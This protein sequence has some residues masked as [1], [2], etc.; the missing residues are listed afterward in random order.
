MSE[1]QLAFKL[2]DETF[3]STDAPYVYIPIWQR[4]VSDDNETVKFEPRPAEAPNER[5]G[6]YWECLRTYELTREDLNRCL[7]DTDIRNLKRVLIER[8][9]A[10][11]G[12]LASEREWEYRMAFKVW[13]ACGRTWL[14]CWLE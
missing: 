12:G 5:D 13:S 10:E 8:L 7:D 6:H 3:A 1:E 11:S 4:K 14:T 9:S 2:A